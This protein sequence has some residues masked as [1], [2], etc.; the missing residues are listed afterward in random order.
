MCFFQQCLDCCGVRW[1]ALHTF[2]DA[3]QGCYKDGTNGTRDCH[4]FAP[5]FLIAWLLLFIIFALGPTILFH[6]GAEFV[7][8]TLAVMI[9]IMKPYKPQFAMYN[10]VDLMPLWC[11]T[12]VCVAISIL[13]EIYWC[14]S[15]YCRIFQTV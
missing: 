13:G 9:A 3:F 6:G 8:I 15:S 14:I 7:F 11:A 2:I 4:Y 5:A 12:V 10:A 1:H